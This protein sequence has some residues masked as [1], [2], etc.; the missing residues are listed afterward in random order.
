MLQNPPSCPIVISSW[1]K[2]IA[3]IGSGL[4]LGRWSALVLVVAETPCR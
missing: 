4:A 3:L 1:L 2:A